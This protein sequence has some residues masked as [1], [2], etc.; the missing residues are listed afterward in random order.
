MNNSVLNAYLNANHPKNDEDKKRNTWETFLTKKNKSPIADLGHM[1]PVHYGRDVSSKRATRYLSGGFSFLSDWDAEELQAT[2]Q[3]WLTKAASGTA[4]AVVKAGSEIAKMPGVL[5][6]IVMATAGQ[7]G[8]LISG[9]DNTD[10][11]QVAFNNSWI[12]SI[13]QW[14][15][16]F[17]EDVLPVYVKKAVRDGNLW[18]NIISMDFWSVDGADGLGFILSMLAPGL[19]I[20]KLGTGVKAANM[21]NKMGVSKKTLEAAG[22]AGQRANLMTATFANTLFEAAVESNHFMNNLVDEADRRRA[23]PIDDPDHITEEQ[24]EE[25][26][27]KSSAGGAKILAANAVILLGPNWIMSKYVYGGAGG[28][29]RFGKKLYDK[30]GKLVDDVPAPSGWARIDASGKRYA[31]ATVS[32]GFWE[33]GMQET[34][35]DYFMDQAFGEEKSFLDTYFETIGSTEGQKAIFLGAVFGGGMYSFQG[36][37]GDVQQAKKATE[38]IKE[39]KDTFSS[40]N[41]FGQVEIYKTKEVPTTDVEGKP[42]TK[43]V[44][45]LDADGNP[46][47]DPKGVIKRAE[48]LG[49]ILINNKAY[50]QALAENDIETI[51]EFHDKAINKLV[52]NLI[53]H[54]EQSL[55]VIDAFIEHSPEIQEYINNHPDPKKGQ[56][57]ITSKIK[58]KVVEGIKA[59][60]MFNDFGDLLDVNNDKATK[61]DYEYFRGFL[62]RKYL[63]LRNSL[64]YFKQQVQ[65]NKKELAEYFKLTGHDPSV[66]DGTNELLKQDLLKDPRLEKLFKQKNTYQNKV[67]NLEQQ[68]K[69]FWDAKKQ[70][71]TFDKM[72]KQQEAIEEAT[73][74]LEEFEKILS[75]IENA[76]TLEDLD[77]ITKEDLEN[78]A[79]KEKYDLKRKEV[80]DFI[81]ATE[82]Q[83]KEGQTKNQEDTQ[84]ETEEKGEVVENPNPTPSAIS[85][86]EG[87][88]IH[89]ETIPTGT[90][91]HSETTKKEALWQFPKMITWDS[92]NNKFFSWITEAWQNFIRNPKN[93]KDTPVTFKVNPV[94]GKTKSSANWT[95]AI[96][97]FNKKV[98]KGIEL[99][100]EEKK[101]LIDHLPINVHVTESVFAPLETQKYGDNDGAKY[102]TKNTRPLRVKI[103][104]EAIKNK[105]LEGIQ[106]FTGE[107]FPGILKIAPKVD[108]KVVENDIRELDAVQ[109]KLINIFENLRVV[110]KPGVLQK[111]DKTTTTHINVDGETI[112]GVGELYLMI[113]RANGTMFPLKL[114]IKKVSSEQADVLADIYNF[115]LKNK[116]DYSKG[117]LIEKLPKFLQDKIKRELAP[118]LSVIKKALGKSYKSVTVK[119]IIDILVWDNT[120]NK[121]T[122]LRLSGTGVQGQT[123]LKFGNR[124]VNSLDGEAR[125]EFIEWLT[126]NKRRNVQ[127]AKGAKEG[128]ASLNINDKAY[129]DYLL[130]TKVLNTNA[131]VNEPTFQGYTDIYLADNIINNNIP[132]ETTTETQPEIV[133]TVETATDLKPLSETGPYERSKDNPKGDGLY[134]ERIGGELYFASPYTGKVYKATKNDINMEK[135]NPENFIGEHVQDNKIAEQMEKMVAQGFFAEEISLNRYQEKKPEKIRKSQKKVVPLHEDPSTK[136]AETVEKVKKEN[137][138]R[139]ELSKVS[140]EQTQAIMADL[141]KGGFFRN[142]KVQNIIQN[143]KLTGV[144]KLEELRT[145]INEL[146]ENAFD[147]LLKKHCK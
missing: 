86:T 13:E 67:D 118:E 147:D 110:L 136:E 77:N 83:E 49:N 27:A 114:N 17:N 43:T 26:V 90:E 143:T 24:Y 108:G 127:F 38:I 99:T 36:R 132:A 1:G 85:K 7:I 60:E 5:G 130:E 12:N 56:I 122:M 65:K 58:E 119:D 141:A 32:E 29:N 16:D 44:L 54:G 6:G 144:Q 70:Q 59:N 2:K 73:E 35:E 125:S 87:S 28:A 120:K 20:T 64:N 131:V 115:A 123:V 82:T 78:P 21:L 37:R 113:P 103:I 72:M 19:A 84:K 142:K 116:S 97:V 145:V 95:K 25:I 11:M 109:K 102:F 140:Q 112:R 62:N 146:K 41:D 101:T 66:L 3:P 74:K 117:M 81:K 34:A 94:F 124:S 121:K 92:A 14:N 48:I 15:K 138:K 47:L 89:D 30:S 139:N 63:G 8:D 4:R 88:E 129:L 104:N 100:A 61:Q 126:N 76:T 33:E 71:E 98:L 50:H 52:E 111:A 106:G 9:E 39:V 69:E 75:K 42:T 31:K 134:A 96:N 93:K 137:S 10:F 22:F 23:L 133:E 40:V 79:V 18:D 91:G 128:I 51:N 55:E 105:S 80:N 53:L 135:E 68:E 45:D 46:Q 57:E 107:Q